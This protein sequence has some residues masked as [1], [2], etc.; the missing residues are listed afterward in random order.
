M[1]N[2]HPKYNTDIRDII[3][4]LYIWYNVVTLISLDSQAVQTRGQGR[5]LDGKGKRD[6][7]E[8]ESEAPHS[9]KTTTWVRALTTRNDKYEND[10]DKFD[11]TNTKIIIRWTRNDEYD[12]YNTKTINPTLIT[13][14]MSGHRT[15][16]SSSGLGPRVMKLFRRVKLS[17]GVVSFCRWGSSCVC[18]FWTLLDLGG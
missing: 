1:Q 13:K 16:V 2:V 15:S 8:T 14:T 6:R 9:H 4:I 7:P 12:N 11:I 18:A 5:Q 17:R 3:Q 10:N